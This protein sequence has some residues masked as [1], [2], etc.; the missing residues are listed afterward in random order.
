M[1]SFSWMLV[2]PN[3]RT[4][5]VCKLSSSFDKQ[6]SRPAAPTRHLGWVSHNPRAP[7]WC[8]HCLSLLS[9]TVGLPGAC[10]PEGGSPAAQR[11]PLP[12]LSY[13]DWASSS[14]GQQTCGGEATFSICHWHKVGVCW[15]LCATSTHG[16]HERGELD[17]KEPYILKGTFCLFYS[18][19][20]GLLQDIDS[21][22][23]CYIVGPCCL[24]VLYN[25]V[26]MLTPTSAYL[27][28]A[29]TRFGNHCFLCQ[30]SLFSFYK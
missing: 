13:L 9:R 21:S 18:L 7:P 20:Y 1:M 22:S 3:A 25:S 10:N 19:H 6:P 15:C 29:L 17:L 12:P 16:V 2:H 4:P 14:S 5:S 30:V 27:H 26:Y 23:P 8:S 11:P 24:P 28:F